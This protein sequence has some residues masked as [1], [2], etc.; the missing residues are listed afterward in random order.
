MPPIVTLTTDFGLQDSF[1]G[2]LKGVLL[3]R[4]PA[5]QVVDLTH[6]V[7][8]QN[9]RIGALRLASA[10]P[11]FPPGAVH[12][13]V[14]DPGVG[15]SRRAIAVAANS[16]AFVGPDNGLLA[17]AAPRSA[18]DWR[19]AHLTN[20]RYWLPDVSHTFHG[21][22]VFAPV[23]AFLACG[24]RLEDIG[25]PIDSIVDISLPGIQ[26]VGDRLR[27]VVL[28]VDRFGNLVTNV[29]A[30]DLEG[31]PAFR[32]RIAGEE[33]EGL[34]DRYDPSRR[35]VAVIDSDGWV[36]VAAPGRSA[37]AMLGAGVDTPVEV[38]G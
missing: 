22:D 3:S 8:P 1:V 17:L 33:I 38:G 14:V 27:G 15:G 23:A 13:A 32:I 2:A 35:L 34:S 26:R 24:G 9:V 18:A 19:A 16:H 12:L 25:E 31:C 4:C 6:D 11:H 7:P 10:A 36:E 37:A 21:R 5:A 20:E 28:D 29:R 30:A